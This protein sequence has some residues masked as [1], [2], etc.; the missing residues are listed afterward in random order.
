MAGK[1]NLKQQL[2][3]DED[4]ELTLKILGAIRRP[5]GKL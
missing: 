1:T 4:I 5:V 2:M 3:I